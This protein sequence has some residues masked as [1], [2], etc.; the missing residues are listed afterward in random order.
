MKT[1]AA[2]T[3]PV[4]VGQQRRKSRGSLVNTG[5]W[6]GTWSLSQRAGVKTQRTLS[7]L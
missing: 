2:T 1:V 5:V 6:Q 4:L 7:S 3:N